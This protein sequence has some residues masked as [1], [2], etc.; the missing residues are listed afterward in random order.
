MQLAN[1]IKLEGVLEE[2]MDNYA[3]LAEFGYFVDSVD[4]QV[5]FRIKKGSYEALIKHA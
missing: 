3:S 5:E 2:L 4:Q 1:Y